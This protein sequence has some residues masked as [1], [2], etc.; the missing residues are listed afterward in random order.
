MKRTRRAAFVVLLAVL[1]LGSGVVAVLVPCCESM[2]SGAGLMDCC[3]NGGPDHECEHMAPRTERETSS[4][5]GMHASCG[6]GHDD[7]VPL[8]GFM[9]VPPPTV[10][11]RVPHRAPAPFD[12]V[13]PSAILRAV[14]PA[15]PPPKF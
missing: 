15:T 7:G 5:G 12:T 3:L 1:H 9:G 13:S 4:P 14:H 2:T 11:S 10:A 6:A 8:L